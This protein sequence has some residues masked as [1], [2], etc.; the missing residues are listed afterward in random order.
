MTE[1][2]QRRKAADRYKPEPVTTLLVG[3]APPE[4]LD[5]YFFFE[6]VRTADW[7]FRYVAKGW[8]GLSALPARTEKQRYLR[9]LCEDGV[10]L[11]DV[12]EEPVTDR[13]SLVGC[14]DDLVRRCQELSPRYI[15]LI[16]TNVFDLCYSPLRAAQLPA[17]NV[18]IPFPAA[19]RQREFEFAFARALEHC[20]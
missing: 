11:I 5:R 19:G 10:W 12:S 14:I 20:P 2:T 13:R 16:K 1:L 3:E 18:R 9:R 17:V 15:I 8:F 7:L 6:D 4:A